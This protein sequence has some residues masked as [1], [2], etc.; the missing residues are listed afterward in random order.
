MENWILHEGKTEDL[1]LSTRVRL[2]RNVERVPFP[3]KLSEDTGRRLL[4]EIEDVFYNGNINKEDFDTLYLWEMDKISKEY[5]LDKHIF[6]ERLIENSNKAALIT[7]NNETTSI[8]INE[9]DHIRIQCI[10]GGLNLNEC[11]INANKIDD[12]LAQKLKFA[13]NDK[14]GYL[15]ACPTNIGTGLRLSVMIHLPVLTSNNEMTEIYKALSQVGMTVRGI[16]GEGSEALGNIYQISNQITLGHTE[17]EMA[18]N[19]Y[20][21]INQ[22]VY[23]ENNSRQQLQMKYKFELED[24]IYR[25]Y[26]ILKTAILLNERECLDLLSNVRLGVELGIIKNISIATLNALLVAV[27]SAVIQM[28]SGRLMGEKERNVMRAKLVKEKII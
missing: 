27:Q 20:A 11:L 22:I 4:W 5:F 9:E 2:A 8:M 28:D 14:L 15:T 25:S 23:K 13:F 26:G 18:V 7:D 21:V 12:L 19:L 16:H 3:G 17:E 24:K 1:V 6:S 10:T